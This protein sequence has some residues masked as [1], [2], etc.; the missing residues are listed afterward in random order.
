L[1]SF[2]FTANVEKKKKTNQSAIDSAFIKIN[3]IQHLLLIG[4]PKG[5]NKNIHPDEIIKIRLEVDTSPPIDKTIVTTNSLLLL[6]F[7]FSI[8]TYRLEDLFAGKVH[9][10]LC[11]QWK[12]R[13]KGRDWY[14]LVW[15][16]SRNIPLNLNH[17]ELRMR[18]S[19]HWRERQKITLE[20]FINLFDEKI[21]NLDITSA[22][23]DIIN[24]IDDPLKL[25][26]WSKDF[27][28]Q[29]IRKIRFI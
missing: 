17:L 4:L 23:N 28:K 15:F 6:P 8:K 27:F 13:V 12:G 7:P 25:E 3:T 18:Q 20:D 2:G 16:V 24:F 22:K 29:I 11:R 26:L 5:I 14:D 19:S 9:A 10:T 21:N 1:Q